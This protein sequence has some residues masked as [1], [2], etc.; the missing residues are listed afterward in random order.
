[1][2]NELGNGSEQIL[3][4]ILIGDIIAPPPT[5]H[6]E[7]Q[8]DIRARAGLFPQL[9][10]MPENTPKLRKNALKLWSLKG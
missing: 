7:L 4:V 8:R 1:M 5:F 2:S 3:N 10:L 9:G 6:K